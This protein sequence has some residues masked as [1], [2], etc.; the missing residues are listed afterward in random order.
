MCNRLYDRLLLLVRGRSSRGDYG[1]ESG[2]EGWQIGWDRTG[3]GGGFTRRRLCS[4]AEIRVWI[5]PEPDPK[6]VGSGSGFVFQ[7]RTSSD[8]VGLD[9]TNI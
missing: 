2:G 6:S 8:R 1:F 7:I 3:G 4:R 5:K 9:I